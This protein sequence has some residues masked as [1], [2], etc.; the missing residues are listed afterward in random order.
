[1]KKTLIVL[2]ICISG[3]ALF[4][5]EAAKP[6]KPENPRPHIEQKENKTNPK[7]DDKRHLKAENRKFDRHAPEISREKSDKG[8]KKTEEKKLKDCRKK[9]HHPERHEHR[10]HHRR[11]VLGFIIH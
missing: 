4:A 3:S 7:T 2:M 1:M 9:D 8:A 10:R 5:K 6:A 11:H